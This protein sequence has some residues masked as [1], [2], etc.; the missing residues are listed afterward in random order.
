[1]VRRWRFEEQFCPDIFKIYCALANYDIFAGEG[2]SHD[3]GDKYGVMLMRICTKRKKAI[4]AAP[5]R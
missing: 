5:E 2:G 1:M 3:A 4:E